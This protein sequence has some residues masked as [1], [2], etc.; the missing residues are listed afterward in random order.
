[1]DQRELL[2]RA[3]HQVGQNGSTILPPIYGP[4]FFN[5]DMG[6]F[7]NFAYHRAPDPAVPGQRL[8]L[9][10][11]SAV[12]VQRKQSQPQLRSHTRLQ[13]NNSTFGTAVNKQGHRIVELAVKYYF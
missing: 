5:W 6:L 13:Q 2:R 12:V 9:V 11:P 4:A 3:D 8:Q 7:K 1:M 10:E